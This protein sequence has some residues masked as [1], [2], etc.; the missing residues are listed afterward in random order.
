MMAFLVYYHLHEDWTL[1][2]L[3]GSRFAAQVR[4]YEAFHEAGPQ[5]ALPEGFESASTVRQQTSSL[6][7]PIPNSQS[8]VGSGAPSFPSFVSVDGFELDVGL[9]LS[10]PPCD[11][12]VDNLAILSSFVTEST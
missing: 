6:A 10:I 1:A 11:S 4:A 9:L 5:P 12:S 8:P 7:L 3:K 2:T